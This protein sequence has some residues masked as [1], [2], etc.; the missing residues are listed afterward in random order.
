METANKLIYSSTK[1]FIENKEEYRIT[2]TISLDDDCHN[3]MCDWSV[4]ADIRQ[5]DQ[6][7][8]YVEYMGGCCHGEVA[9]HFPEL[10]KFI[11][12]N[13]IKDFGMKPNEEYNNEERWNSTVVE[14][15][16][17][18][19]L[20]QLEEDVRFGFE[21]ALNQRGISASLMFECVMMWN[22]ILEEGLEDWDEDDY[23]FYGL[24][25]FKATA[26]KYGWDNPIG[27]DS[28]RERKYDSQY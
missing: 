15:T 25:L 13:M 14:F 18:N 16:R 5:K 20:K 23:R 4:T 11:P 10:A 7:G 9:K 3:N 2:V 12:Y 6:Q 27:E 1:F 19:V 21:K 24:P 8:T 17:E 26:V 28:G 22:Y